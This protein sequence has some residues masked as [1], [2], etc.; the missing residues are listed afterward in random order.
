MTYYEF[1]KNEME[2][3]GLNPTNNIGITV[4]RLMEVLDN[5]KLSN[6]DVAICSCYFRQFSQKFPIRPHRLEVVDSPV[7]KDEVFTEDDGKSWSS[8]NP[9]ETT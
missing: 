6:I 5:Q 7:I 8:I 9:R 2:R 3:A 1:A 4:L